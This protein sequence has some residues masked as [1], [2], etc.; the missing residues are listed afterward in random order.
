MRL[1]RLVAAPLA[2]GILMLAQLAGVGPARAAATDMACNYDHISFNACLDFT[3]TG[4][5]EWRAHAGL[6]AAMPQRYAQEI[7]DYGAGFRASLF[8]DD[9]G[10]GQFLADLTLMPGWPAAG[11]T[12]LGAE[13]AATLSSTTL[14]EDYNDEDEIYAVVSFFDYHRGVTVAF[15]TG[16]VHGEFAPVS[17]GGGG[18][19]CLVACP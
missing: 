16:T 1:S 15:R 18:G 8:G 17:E 11:P 3:H 14:D 5:N 13:F 4:L 10:T 6:D 9:H 2:A 19:G 12:G 7:I